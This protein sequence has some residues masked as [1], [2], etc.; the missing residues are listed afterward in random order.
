MNKPCKRVL[1]FVL[2][3]ANLAVIWGNSL[4]TGEDSGQFSAAV[5]AF[6]CRFIPFVSGELG[7][8]ILR[9]LAHFSEVACL[10][11]LTGGFRL[12]RKKAGFGIPGF[13]MAV[14]CVDETIQV[15]T[16]D[17]GPSPIDIWIDTCGV[18]AGIMIL[19][20]GYHYV[21]KKHTHNLEEIK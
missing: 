12:L 16:P 15:F 20:L 8:T 1:L 4:M 13:G 7:H 14:A 18:A 11:L 21:C 19:I 6:L 3:C 17:R 5:L 9:K 2:I 10:G